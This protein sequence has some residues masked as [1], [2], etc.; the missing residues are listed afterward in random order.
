MEHLKS[1]YRSFDIRGEYPAEL[2]E[3]ETK[4]VAQAICQMCSP[5]LVVVG[6]D[7]RPSSEALYAALIEG[8]I[9]QGVDV[10]SLGLVTTPMLYFGAGTHTADVSVMVSGSHMAPQFNGLKICTENVTPIGLEYG[11][12]KVRDLVQQNDFTPAA[13]L[14]SVTEVDIKPQWIE[15]CRELV[16]LTSDKPLKVVVDPANMVGI[17]E[18]DT[19]KAFPEL[20][21]TSIYDEYDWSLPH[22]EAN[23][24]K[25]ETMQDLGQK[26]REL[27]ADMGVALDGDADRIGIVD[28]TGSP[29]PQDV[30]GAMIASEL[31]KQ[32]AGLVIQD[33]RSSKHVGELV[34]SLGGE[35]LPNRIGHTHIR[36]KMAETGAM[37][38]FELS[39]HH[40]FKEMFNSEAGIYP[41]LLLMQ[42]LQ[43]S[44]KKLSELAAEH[45]VYYHSSEINSEITQSPEEIYK[46]L[47][48][49]FPDAEFETIDGLTIKYDS[50]W[51]NVR[52]SANDPVMRL[53]LEAD[54]PDLMA[55]KRDSVLKIIRA[56][57]A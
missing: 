49:A 18:I 53:N 54:A 2:N 8:F 17:L 52:P 3:A 7:Y 23:P 15:R 41:A 32:Q 56:K 4:K 16:S 10:L 43:G 35:I 31:L 1:I 26:V 20:E 12:D 48:A 44:G 40:F 29:I 57:K 42:L 25:L 28:E 37:Y 50:W 55:E 47:R 27:G 24:M 36:R 5:H 14:G 46:A 33:V 22:H 13:T 9:E 39:G 34:T 11:L 51:C 6:H 19:L 38:A 21:V 30:I 45:Q